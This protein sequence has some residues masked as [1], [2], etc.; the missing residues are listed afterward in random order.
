M[1]TVR[2][3]RR[4]SALAL[5][6][7]LFASPAIAQ[8][9][10]P[11]PIVR[12]RIE[13]QSPVMVG[14]TVTLSVDVLTPT[15]FP[16]A[17]QFPA[18]L[19]VENAVA[20]FDE[21]YR[22]N[23]SERIDGESWSGL[24]RHY[25]IY[26]QLAG[27]YTVPPVEVVVV[28][29]LPNARPSEPLTLASPALRFEARVPP[30]A[31][32]LDYFIAA[33][34][35]SLEQKV[36][37]RAE[38]LRV[39]DALTRTVTLRATDASSMM[40]PITEFPTVDGLAVYP[41]PTRASDT[42]SERGEAREATRVDG[43]TYVLENEGSY[44]LPA[45]E[46]SWWDVSSGRLRQVSVPAVSFTVAPN[47][48][49]AG[50]I[51]L[52]DEPDDAEAAPVEETPW[53]RRWEALAGL[54]VFGFLTWL[55]RRYGPALLARREESERRRQESEGA[56]FDR[57]LKACGRD[58]AP[59]TMQALLAWVDRGTPRGQSPTLGRLLETARD[60]ELSRAVRDLEDAL[61]GQGDAAAWRGDS[62]A[63]SLERVRRARRELRL[64][65]EP[66]LLAPLNPRTSPW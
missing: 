26:P 39:G 63:R 47:P 21:S 45:V 41:D 44:T 20:V 60:E 36:E 25:L 40:L 58:D 5:V 48:D 4:L 16:R 27:A 30:E 23:L 65:R 2:A 37:P 24:R 32:G 51:A 64:D 15:W 17:P 31:A 54:A 3:G 59:G 33:R 55:A 14:E 9:E 46:R 18:A 56:Y 7:S 50:E 49:L 1:T 22:T 43:A 13:T 6:S 29:A 53:W 66:T 52:P 8:D 34:D 57:V 12:A 28:Y 10:G 38:G 35:F 19:Q 61:Y 11:R 62:L 42:G